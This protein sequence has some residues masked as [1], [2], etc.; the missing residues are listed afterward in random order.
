MRRAVASILTVFLATAGEANVARAQ[1]ALTLPQ[2]ANQTVRSLV[3]L[4]VSGRRTDG[5][6]AAPMNG[7]GVMVHPGGWV[8]TAAHCIGADHEWAKGEDGQ[9]IRSIRVSSLDE[10]GVERSIPFRGVEVFDA[11]RDVALLRVMGTGHPNYWISQA[12]P[13]AAGT[14]VF[15]FGWGT[16]SGPEPVPGTLLNSDDPANKGLIKLDAS[17]QPGD[18]GGPVVDAL[19][20]FIGLVIEGRT[21]LP[22]SIFV[23]P[24][25]PTHPARAAIPDGA[26]PILF[27]TDSPTLIKERAVVELEPR[28]GGWITQVAFFNATTLL[29]QVYSAR[30]VMERQIQLRSRNIIVRNDDLGEVL[31]IPFN[32]RV[33]LYGTVTDSRGRRVAGVTVR[34]GDR[35]SEPS[36]DDG[37]FRLDDLPL[38]DEYL[39]EVFSAHGDGPSPDRPYKTRIFNMDLDL[40][41]NGTV[42]LP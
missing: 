16:R 3:K 33:D 25:L 40:A 12:P 36:T 27:E 6:M 28:I 26:V 20:R 7:T 15:A 13:L 41:R 17:L 34:F 1:E 5:E 31:R 23:T 24:S 18:S 19:G 9:P 37:S 32:Y 35:E 21:D 14:E 8:L 42:T 29:P 22:R 4:R 30:P 11:D 39:L 10:S 38:Q 2:F